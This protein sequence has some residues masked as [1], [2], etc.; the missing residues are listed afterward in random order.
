[1]ITV[2][3]VE[4]DLLFRSALVELL[5]LKKDLLVVGQYATAELGLEGLLA[6]QPRIAILDVRLPGMSGLELLKQVKALLPDT[7]YMMC[8]S[9][10]DNEIV[11]EALKNGALGYLLKHASGEEI[12][13]GIIDLHNGGSP[14]SP[15]IAR[16]IICS[17]QNTNPSSKR[18]DL[19]TREHE[20]LELLACGLLYKEVAGR[21]GISLETVKNHVSNIY[22]KLH[23][24]NK[25]EALKKYGMMS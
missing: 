18:L 25:V 10:T 11:F 9:H 3:I 6:T 24:E 1:M 14:I 2:A 20:V 7:Q 5:K 12:C 19:T 23:V 8:T 13:Q 22:K 16:K 4:D 21:L 15:Y 17:M